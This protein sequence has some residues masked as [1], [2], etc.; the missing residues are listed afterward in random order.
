MATPK[1][2]CTLC[3]KTD[4]RSEIGCLNPERLTGMRHEWLCKAEKGEAVTSLTMDKQEMEDMGEEI[5]TLIGELEAINAQS[6]LD[7]SNI[8]KLR[9]KITEIDNVTA[10]YKAWL[11]MND[12]LEVDIEET[13][14]GYI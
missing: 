1:I 9:A 11:Q 14:T 6:G 2:T 12:D 3:G 8:D 7:L 5:T 4:F 13:E 10:A